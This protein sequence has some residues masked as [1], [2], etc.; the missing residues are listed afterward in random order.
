MFA[1]ILSRLTVFPATQFDN[2]EMFMSHA[3]TIG[4]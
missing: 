4:Q 3:T 2:V 1:C